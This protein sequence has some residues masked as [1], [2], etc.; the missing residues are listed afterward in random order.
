MDIY[1][2]DLGRRRQRALLQWRVSSLSSGTSGRRLAG[3]LIP[4]PAAAG[5]RETPPHL[6]WLGRLWARGADSPPEVAAAGLDAMRG[7]TYGLL[8][9]MFGGSLGFWLPAIGLAA[10]GEHAVVFL[11][12]GLGSL[13][14]GVGLWV[15]GIWLRRVC[16]PPVSVGEIE[17][18]QA[19]VPDEREQAYLRLAADAVRQSVAPEAAERVRAALRAEAAQAQAEAR[20]ETDSV[21]AASHERRA[22]ALERSASAA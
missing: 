4:F 20:A 21:V 3:S 19:S 11:M 12:A 15:P 18:L 14:N 2:Q 16:R 6:G 17:A 9:G 5:G 7:Q 13:M 1:L 22:D 10:S 8:G